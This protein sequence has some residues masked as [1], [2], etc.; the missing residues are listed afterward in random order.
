MRNKSKSRVKVHLRK[1]NSHEKTLDNSFEKPVGR[2]ST[3]SEIFQIKPVQ[4][5]LAMTLSPKKV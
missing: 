5:Q 1:H 2:S 4:S 3:K